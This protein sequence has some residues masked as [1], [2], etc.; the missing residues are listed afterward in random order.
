MKDKRTRRFKSIKA[1][2]PHISP[3]FALSSKERLIKNSQKKFFCLG[4]NC[5]LKKVVYARINVMWG[6]GFGFPLSQIFL[7]LWIFLK[8]DLET[9]SQLNILKFSI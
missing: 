7:V 3:K 6:F 1:E 2:P 8:H 5:Q 4:T 9:L